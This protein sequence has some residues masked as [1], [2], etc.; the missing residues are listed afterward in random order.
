MKLEIRIEETFPPRTKLHD[1]K[2][3]C[4]NKMET[5]LASIV[6]REILYQVLDAVTYE[7]YHSSVYEQLE[8]GS[9]V[10][11]FTIVAKIKVETEKMVSTNLARID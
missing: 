10:L 2:S 11:G 4:S 7:Y 5:I 1:A 9:A 3:F 8:N 6:E